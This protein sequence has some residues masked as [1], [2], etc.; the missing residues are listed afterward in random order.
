MAFAQLLLADG[1]AS[2]HAHGRNRHEEDPQRAQAVRVHSRHDDL[3]RFGELCDDVSR[4]AG[5]PACEHGGE[6]RTQRGFQRGFVGHH[7]VL[8][9]DTPDDDGDGG[10]EVAEEAEGCRCGRDVAGRDE[11][12]QGDERSLEVWPHAQAGDDLVGEDAAPGSGGGD[13]DVEAETDGH[14]EHAQPNWGEVLA[15]FLDEY[16]G[17]D[18]GE[19]EGEDEGEEVDAREDGGGAQHGLEVEGQEVRARDE[20]HAVD[21]ADGEGGHV[22]A[23]FEEPERHDGVPG[24]FPFVEEEKHD[25]D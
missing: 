21:E 16:A 1:Q 4:G 18:G 19:G 22:G 7:S 25:G 6:L 24:E 20:D 12:L 11:R 2:D 5:A 9:Y 3:L 10:G 8:E 14:E 13:V 17:D 15:C 23:V